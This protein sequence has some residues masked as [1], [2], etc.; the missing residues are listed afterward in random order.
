MRLQDEL[1]MSRPPTEGEDVVLS[2]LLTRE[3]LA[4][5]LERRIFEAEGLSD[6]QYNLLRILRGGPPEG[7]LVQDIRRRM[8]FR[9]ADVSRLAMRLEAKGLVHR[10][11][12]PEDRRGV[13]VTITAAGRELTERLGAQDR[14]ASAEVAALLTPEERAGLTETLSRLRDGLR[15]QA[16]RT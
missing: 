1:R 3:F 5:Y 13:R 12:D 16:D 8:I 11:E 7:Y 15:D 6:P 4:R 2:L 9:F 10:A 14:A